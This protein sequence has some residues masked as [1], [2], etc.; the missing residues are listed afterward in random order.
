MEEEQ[1]PRQTKRKEPE[2]GEEKQERVEAKRSKR[3]HIALNRN[4]ST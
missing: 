3:M 4:S 2:T 1:P